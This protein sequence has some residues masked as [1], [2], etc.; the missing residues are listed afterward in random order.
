MA[1][2]EC[3]DVGGV[4]IYELDCATCNTRTREAGA[5]HGHGILLRML[6]RGSR[7]HNFNIPFVTY[8]LKLIGVQRGAFMYV[9]TSLY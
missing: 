3:N 5:V 7:L 8:T 9:Y 1:A 4:G 2:L 6:G